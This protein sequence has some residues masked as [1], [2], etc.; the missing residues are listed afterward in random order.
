M[1][2]ELNFESLYS[3]DKYGLMHQ[4]GSVFFP[5]ANYQKPHKNSDGNFPRPTGMQVQCASAFLRKCD[6]EAFHLRV[7][8]WINRYREKEFRDFPEIVPD[9]AGISIETIRQNYSVTYITFPESVCEKADDFLVF[10]TLEPK[11][12]DSV[13]MILSLT[14][15]T[16]RCL[17]IK[18]YTGISA[19][20]A[21]MA[22]M[23]ISE[24]L[25][26]IGASEEYLDASQFTHVF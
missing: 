11:W 9:A 6:N 25:K 15:D 1:N 19:N 8:S 14:K 16:I 21:I 24:L 12:E 5:V 20:H 4:T 13:E 3:D 2:P 18:E 17:S 26:W 7:D 22:P 23:S 10:C